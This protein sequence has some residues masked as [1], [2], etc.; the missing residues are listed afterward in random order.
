MGFAWVRHGSRGELAFLRP[1]SL[2]REDAC[3]RAFFT[4]RWGGVSVP[5]FASLNLGLHVGDDPRAVRENRRVVGEILAFPPENWAVAQQIHGTT[6]VRVGPEDA[7]AGALSL[8]TAV[9]GVDGLLTT[10][11]DLPLVGFFADCVPLFF[12]DDAGRMVGLAHAGWRGTAGGIGRRMLQLFREEL[13]VLPERIRVALGPAIGPCCYRVGEE[14]AA[15]FPREV[16]TRDAAGVSLNLVRANRLDLE[17]AGVTEIQVAGI[18][19]A[20]RTDLFF[21]H[22]GEKGHTGRMA[23]LIAVTPMVKE[24]VERHPQG[25]GEI[26]R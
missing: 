12:W 15:L 23:A 5:P 22:R 7:G 11:P 19:T 1:E 2:G 4:T 18:C 6:V 21:S 10:A 26:P 24:S 16:V 9:P 20:C 14:V 17:A 13:G 8:S 3:V 25:R